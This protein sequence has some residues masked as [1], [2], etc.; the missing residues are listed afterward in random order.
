MTGV[1]ADFRPDP[2]LVKAL[3][4][5]MAAQRDQFCHLLEAA[6][7]ASPIT[8]KDLAARSGMSRSWVSDRLKALAEI[9]LVTTASR[10]QYY[11]IPGASIAAGLAEIKARADRLAA[12]ARQLIDAQ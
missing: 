1:P 5:V 2:A 4:P 9:G 12:E 3:P 8:P 7:P 10:G 6:T 11:A